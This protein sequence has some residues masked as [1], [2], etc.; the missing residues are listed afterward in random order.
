MTSVFQ[1]I[2]VIVSPYA[3]GI[4]SRKLLSTEGTYSVR[5][6]NTQRVN[7][8]FIYRWNILFPSSFLSL[9]HLQFY[10]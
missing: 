8:H 6:L 1:V 4:F 7:M 9:L 3:F 5:L 10:K 2:A